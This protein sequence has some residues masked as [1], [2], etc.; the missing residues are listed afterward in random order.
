MVISSASA[1]QTLTHLRH[2]MHSSTMICGSPRSFIWMA[3]VGHACWQRAPQAMHLPSIS[4]A[5]G[6]GF[7][8]LP[9]GC[10]GGLPDA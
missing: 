7:L 5:L 3:S 2:P 1:G 4:R 8:D 6:R 10:S 9:D